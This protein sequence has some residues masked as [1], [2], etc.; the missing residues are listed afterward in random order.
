M[1]DGQLDDILGS[2]PDSR[3]SFLKK[4]AVTTAF[5]TPVVSSFTMSGLSMAG[6]ANGSNQSWRA[7]NLR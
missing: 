5:A 1:D 2:V 4:L 6:A 7:S 3:R